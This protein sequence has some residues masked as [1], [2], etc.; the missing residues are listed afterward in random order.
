[1]MTA[2]LNALPDPT[3]PPAT[4]GQHSLRACAHKHAIL[5]FFPKTIYFFSSKI[6]VFVVLRFIASRLFC[7]KTFSVLT[8]HKKTCNHDF[9][10]C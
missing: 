5:V 4:R 2:G 8:E 9:G 3:I 6:P 1:M 7:W 10:Q